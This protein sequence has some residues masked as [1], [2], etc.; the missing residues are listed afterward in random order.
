MFRCQEK[1]EVEHGIVRKGGR[2]DETAKQTASAEHRLE[3]M[4]GKMDEDVVQPDGGRW[5]LYN[6]GEDG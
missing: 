1:R 2:R 3:G 5:P 6:M 4:K